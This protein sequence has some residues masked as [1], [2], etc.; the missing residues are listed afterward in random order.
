LLEGN[1]S[2][3][4]TFKIAL[5]NTGHCCDLLHYLKPGIR[6]LVTVVPEWSDETPVATDS[7]VK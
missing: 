3:V 5:S 7:E 4:H 1:L 6:S 2:D